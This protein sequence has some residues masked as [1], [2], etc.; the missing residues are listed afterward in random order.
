MFAEVAIDRPLSTTFH[1]QV[2]EHLQSKIQCG[3]MVQ[4]PFR[5]QAEHGI[6]VALQTERPDDLPENITLKDVT[7]ILHVEP[8]VND[9]QLALARWLSEH[10]HA[11]MASALRLLTPPGLAGGRD[12]LVTL[13]NERAVPRDINHHRVIQLLRKRGALRGAQI[14][15][16]FAS[17]KKTTWRKWLDQLADDDIIQIDP[18]LKPPSIK[19]R[20]VQT[21]TLAIPPDHIPQVA[22]TLGKHSRR[23]DLLELLGELGDGVHDIRTIKD[24]FG[25]TKATLQKMVDEGL[26][27]F[28]ENDGIQLAI[29]NDAI[30]D[31]LI[32]LRQAEK[33]IHVLRVLAREA[34]PMDVSWLYM[35]TDT[36]LKD[37]RQL[38]E[39]GCIQL[40]ERDDWREGP[41][42][43]PHDYYTPPTLTEYQQAALA[44]IVEAID[45]STPK[46]FLL[47]GVTGSGKTEIYLQAIQHALNNG[48]TAIFLVPEIALTPQTTARAAGRFPRKVTVIHSGLTEGERYD[49]WRRARQG[50]A[51]VVIGPRSA[52]F[53]PLDNIGVIVLDE[54]HDGSYKQSP[55]A[56]MP[57][58]RSAPHYHAR[59]TAEYLAK[60]HNAVVI[61]GSA[62]PDVE[63]VY[64]AERND[65][66][67]LQLP[68]RILAH[69]EQVQQQVEQ[70]GVRITQPTQANTP[71]TH[72]L[73]PVEVVDMRSEL[74]SGNT[75]MFS[76]A[77]RYALRETLQRG[78]QALLFLNRRGK[79]TYVFCRDC[80]YVSMCPNCDTPLIYH[81][82]GHMRCHRCNHIERHPKSC[83]SCT[84]RRIR[85]FGAGTQ[86]IESTLAEAFPKARILRWDADTI[87]NTEQHTQFL[88]QLTSRNADII[89]GTQMIAKGLDL[90]LVTLVGIVSAD[91]A[92]N[93]PDFR[94]GERSFQLLTQVAG[95]AGRSLLGGKVILQTYQPEH[96]A[97]SAAAHHDYMAFYGQEIHYRR[98]LGYPPFRRMMRL[99]VSNPNE[100]HAKDL[101]QQIAAQLHQRITQTND[102]ETEIIG[103][104][105]AFFTKIANNY[106]W[107]VL[108]RGTNPPALLEGITLDQSVYIDIDPADML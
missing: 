93:L 62:T 7:A 55:N 87:A 81:H 27:V 92:L 60:L 2:P 67:W 90:P 80:G 23:A 96:Y 42:D 14:T 38:E 46:T 9:N 59:E 107:H 78:E 83:P 30:N 58:Y 40:G 36:T 105:P 25:T 32:E 43:K 29:D 88:Q 64:R 39:V 15:N 86:Q 53:A 48:R 54:E 57:A 13:L 74:K 103:P 102:T 37:L 61:L 66:H 77:L 41:A 47:H 34:Q 10:Y 100:A 95:R 56:D 79:N 106:R 76:G 31:K 22:P 49:A 72:D 63:T 98:Q 35:Q 12:I 71:Y 89:V 24:S 16:A 19:P 26:L 5:T 85:F 8:V 1:Y 20:T 94:T 82:D 11:N 45:A 28:T 75:S 50:L 65:I 70:F 51:Q 84:S 101:V 104:A 73:P 17:E 44:P 18:I 33:H 6:V 99:L 108:V 97:V 52:L 21:A 4:V 69:Q 91:I 3:H 68:R